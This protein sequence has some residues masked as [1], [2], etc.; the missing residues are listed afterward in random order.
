[1]ILIPSLSW[2]WRETTRPVV[3]V[4]TRTRERSPW[5]SNITS[6]VNPEGR[7]VRNDAYAG[8]DHLHHCFIYLRKTL[9]PGVAADTLELGDFM[10]EKVDNNL[11]RVGSILVC[12]D[13]QQVYSVF[14]EIDRN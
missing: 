1:M 10:K 6:V 5:R 12:R 7:N 8:Y 11:K 2:P 3:P 9:L 14:H 13:W 4:S